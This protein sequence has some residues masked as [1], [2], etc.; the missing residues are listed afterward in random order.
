MRKYRTR[1]VRVRIAQ[2]GRAML[3]G[4][5]YRELRSIL[6]AASLY[7]SAARDK[8]FKQESEHG[9]LYYGR[10]ALECADCAHYRRRGWLLNTAQDAVLEAIDA[11]DTSATTSQ[12]TL[13]E[14]LHAQQV[15]RAD[16]ARLMEVV[17][18][19]RAP[20]PVASDT[21]AA[22]LH[23]VA[24]TAPTA[25]ERT[26][27]G[28]LLGELVTHE[29]QAP[30]HTAMQARNLVKLPW[31]HERSH[32]PGASLTEQLLDECGDD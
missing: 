3:C 5:N 26:L 15:E 29:A 6:T 17:A 13:A 16:T 19:L 1:K 14:R 22:L 24:Q 21:A 2:N 23:N 4:L 10:G 28:Q 25:R 8:H 9:A 31:A 12:P 30:L 27:A 11:T 7:N 20:P 32:S 18:G